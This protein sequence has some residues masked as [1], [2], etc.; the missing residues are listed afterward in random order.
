MVATTPFCLENLKKETQR[1]LLKDVE[2]FSR[3]VSEAERALALGRVRAEVPNGSMFC[4]GPMAPFDGGGLLRAGGPKK[5]QGQS[6]SFVTQRPDA[7]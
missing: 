1:W 7:P 3:L 5:S 4:E 6:L 2:T